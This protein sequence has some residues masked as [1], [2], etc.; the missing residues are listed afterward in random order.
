MLMPASFL[1][2]CNMLGRPAIVVSWMIKL[3]GS[4]IKYK[5]T[6]ESASMFLLHLD[7][8][9][10]FRAVKKQCMLIDL[11]DFILVFMCV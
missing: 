11:T 7:M 8:C 10:F 9:L 1:E 3:T 5:V 4:L 2:D 6:I